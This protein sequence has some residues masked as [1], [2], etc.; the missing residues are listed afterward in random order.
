MRSLH[1]I[2]LEVALLVCLAPTTV[3][4]AEFYV[5]PKGSDSAAGTE[6]APFATVGKAQTAASAGDT[7]YLRGGVYKFSGTSATVGVAF[8]KSGTQSQRLNYFAYPGEVPIFDFFELLPNARVTGFDVT[9]SWIHIRGVEVRGVQQVIVGDSWGIRIRGSNN[10]IENVNVHHCEAPGVFITSGASNLILNTDSHHNYDPL[11]DGGNGDGFGCHS[12]GGNNVIRGCRAYD[13]SDD[14]F[15]FINA[16]GT[17]SAEQSW[18]FRNG[19]VPDSSTAAGNGAGFKAGGFGSPPQLPSGAVPRHTV[20]QCVAFGNRSQGFYANHHP[21]EI[22]F[23]NN[24][25]F[26]NSV[27]YNMLADSGYPSSHKLR[28]NVAMSPGTAISNLSGGT[29]TSNSWTLSVSVSSADF[30]SVAETEAT[31]P[32][33]ADGSLPDTSFM[34]LASGSD[35]IDKGVDVG[36]PFVGSAPDLGAYESGA[37]SEG[38]GTGGT[39]S[40]GRGGAANAGGASAGQGG[41]NARGGAASLGGA[42]NAGGS[43]VKGGSGGAGAGTIRAGATG[44]GGAPNRAGGAGTE[45]AS[46]GRRASGEGGAAVRA[47]AAPATSDEA[48]GTNTNTGTTPTRDGTGGAG[49]QGSGGTLGGSGTR[50]PGAD[51]AGGAGSGS[52]SGSGTSGN[53]SAAADGDGVPANPSVRGLQCNAMPGQADAAGLTRYALFGLMAVAAGRLRRRSGAQAPRADGENRR[54]R[55]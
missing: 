44:Q 43:A 24:T 54:T 41:S 25:A 27:N 36:L 1:R 7:V 13:N 55:P 33:K 51:G 6:S 39:A 12:D 29:D 23:Y 35:L 28:N 2:G 15:D 52:T 50:G 32:R 22:D 48:G 16:P 38:G 5:S 37:K 10:I 34:R 26:R 47:T 46:G 53:G 18:S 21:G 11:E 3:L 4:A 8:S 9:A 40:T 14:G 19:Y 20:R 17:C 45:A 31:A 30:Q 42:A 49:R